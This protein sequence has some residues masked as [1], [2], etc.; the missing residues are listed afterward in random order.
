MLFSFTQPFFFQHLPAE[1]FFDSEIGE[2]QQ[3]IGVRSHHDITWCNV[4]GESSDPATQKALNC[5]TKVK[6]GKFYATAND[7][8]FRNP[9]AF[10][11]GEIHHHYDTW[12]RISQ[13]YHKKKEILRYI[14][15]GV[16]IHNF[17]TPFQGDFKGQHYNS[18][19]PPRIELANNKSCAAFEQFITDTIL[20][21]IRNDSISI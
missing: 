15:N 13:G 3:G 18:E 2:L 14:A 7:V 17:F 9:N 6:D 4:R 20:E 19:L 5:I 10:V 12:D 11:A 16:S 1:G 21:R 8:V